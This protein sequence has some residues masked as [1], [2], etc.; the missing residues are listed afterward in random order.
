MVDPPRLTAPQIAQKYERALTTVMT[1]W[2]QRATFPDPVGRSGRH[3]TYDAQAVAAYVRDYVDRPGVELEADRLYTAREIEALT[4]IKASTIRADKKRGRWPQPDG[5]S[6]RADVWLGS[7]VTTTLNGRRG[8]HRKPTG[9]AETTPLKPTVAAHFGNDGEPGLSVKGIERDLA[10]AVVNGLRLG[11][12]PLP[13]QH[14]V[15]V[16]HIMSVVTQ[17]DLLIQYLDA[18]RA[19][20]IAAAGAPSPDAED[21]IESH[22]HTIT[23]LGATWQP[24]DVVLDA[25]GNIRVRSDHPKWVWGYASEGPVRDRLLGGRPTVPEGALEEHDVPRP[26]TLLIRDG[27]PIGGRTIEE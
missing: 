27:Q 13:P 22:V 25:E 26:L 14:A 15:S 21:E 9:T 10:E 7:T 5:I 19:L 12:D 4:G 24:G 6:G 18:C 2:T 11:R 1:D 17:T 20:A 3:Y 23:A 8:Y 16:N